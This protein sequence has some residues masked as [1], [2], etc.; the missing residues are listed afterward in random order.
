MA[1][2]GW[3]YRYDFR[4][5]DCYVGKEGSFDPFIRAAEHLQDA[6]AVAYPEKY[7]GFKALFRSDSAKYVTINLYSEAKVQKFGWQLGLQGRDNDKGV[8]FTRQE[9]E[10]LR[11][12]STGRGVSKVYLTVDENGQYIFEKDKG[13]AETSGVTKFKE[14]FLIK[15]VYKGNK[16][17][18]Y[19][20]LPDPTGDYGEL[21][22]KIKNWRYLSVKEMRQLFQVTPAEIT[23]LANTIKKNGGDVTIQKAGA[24]LTR[25]LNILFGKADKDT[26]QRSKTN[27]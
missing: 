14:D 18:E 7:T 23:W 16:M 1:D 5:G 11:K 20:N 25:V 4:N 2:N 13:R 9:I 10:D 15:G 6:L 26:G 19:K 24:D 8:K 17:G 27:D 22:G 21:L 12:R 3:I